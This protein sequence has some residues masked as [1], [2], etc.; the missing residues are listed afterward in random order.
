MGGKSFVVRCI[1]SRNGYGVET[2]A[3]ADTGANAFAIVDTR[4]A[5]KLAEF[6][7]APVEPL[8]QPVPVKG[9]D[10]RKGNPI[11]SIL[12]THLQ[13]DGRRQYNVPLLRIS[14]TMMLF[15]GVSG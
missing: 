1:L 10:G 5:A 11:T 3:L 8:S 9:Y 7:N 13:I 12:R 6:L 4:C 2:T 15:W 14:G